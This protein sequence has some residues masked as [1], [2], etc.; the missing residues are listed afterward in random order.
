MRTHQELDERSRQLH[1]LIASKIR[2]DL[3]LFDRVNKTLNRW[4]TIVCASSQPYLNE[5]EKL[6]EQGVDVCLNVATE[7]SE[8]AN[9]LRQ[10]SPFTGILTTRERSD[11]FK[12]WNKSEPPA[13]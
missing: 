3:S 4:K 10:A 9:A 12:N 8:H 7:K 1:I 6:V 5:W 13:T 2:N 11:F